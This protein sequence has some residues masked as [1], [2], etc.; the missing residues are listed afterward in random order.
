MVIRHCLVSDCGTEGIYLI[1]SAD[2]LL[3][4][5]I[6]TRTNSAEKITDTTPRR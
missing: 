1:N 5:N 4:K 3:E 6:V 2:V